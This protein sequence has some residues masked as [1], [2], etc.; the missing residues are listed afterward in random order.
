VV[1]FVHGPHKHSC[2][3]RE[4]CPPSGRSRAIGAPS[5]PAKKPWTQDGRSPPPYRRKEWSHA[6]VHPTSA[7]GG[8]PRNVRFHLARAN[9]VRRA[10]SR[11]PARVPPRSTEVNAP[12]SVLDASALLAW[13]RDEAGALAAEN[14]LDNV[15]A[16]SVVNWAEVLTK[17]ADLGQS[18]DEV[19]LA[20]VRRGV[21]GNA[22]VLWPL[23]EDL[24]LEIAKLR[25]RTRSSGLSLGDRACIALG[26][27]L[28]VPILT[29]DRAWRTLHLGVQIQVIR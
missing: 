28:R 2:P 26:R 4:L 22:L 3:T 10:D 12:A 20:L 5:A 6:V 9:T 19:R 23:G 8:H 16:M 15:T 24:A 13:L 17:L 25:G 27:Q 29:T 14:A 21:L 7:T 1:H 11:T 18:P